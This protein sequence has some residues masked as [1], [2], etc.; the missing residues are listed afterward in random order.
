M[1]KCNV[2]RMHVEMIPRQMWSKSLLITTEGRRPQIGRGKVNIGSGLQVQVWQGSHG[3]NT[4]R[5]SGL[6]VNVSFAC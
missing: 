3:A 2:V 4:G 5:D 1:M 6:K